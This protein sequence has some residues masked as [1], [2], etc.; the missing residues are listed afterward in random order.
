MLQQVLVLN[1]VAVIVVV[2]DAPENKTPAPALLCFKM[3]LKLIATI[4]F[5]RTLRF[6]PDSESR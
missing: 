5:S 2:D 1:S 4:K 6:R 3:I